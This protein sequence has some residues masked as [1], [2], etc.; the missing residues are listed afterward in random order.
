MVWIL[1]SVVTMNI[2]ASKGYRKSRFTVKKEKSK[3][4]ITMRIQGNRREY[5]EE[6]FG[7]DGKIMNAFLEIFE[8]NIRKFSKNY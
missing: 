6:I 4:I 8:N 7:E 1:V 5:F 2:L 3:V